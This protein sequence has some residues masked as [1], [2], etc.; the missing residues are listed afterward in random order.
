MELTRRICMGRAQV[1]REPGKEEVY[2]DHFLAPLKASPDTTDDRAKT[3][4]VIVDV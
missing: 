1:D 4:T 2:A 3:N